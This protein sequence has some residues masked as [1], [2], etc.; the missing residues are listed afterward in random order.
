[1]RVSW[2]A[3]PFVSAISVSCAS[4]SHSH[5]HSDADAGPDTAEQIVPS[6]ACPGA[7]EPGAHGLTSFE[8]GR[9]V[10]LGGTEVAVVFCNPMMTAPPSD[11]LFTIILSD[12]SAIPDTDPMKGSYLATDRIRVDS[13]LTWD[14]S[15]VF[16]G[17]H[18]GK[19]Y[20]TVPSQ[21]P[22]GAPVL[23]PGTTKMTLHV[24]GIGDSSAD[25]E[26]EQRYLQ[27]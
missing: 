14:G 19:G 11:L 26:W 22:S 1:M 17:D 12:H 27:Y 7:T 8:L 2:L 4:A 15:G 10:A 5:A 13:G 6:A 20:L 16:A 23:G 9:V 24:A 25:F 18:H 3:V 21:T